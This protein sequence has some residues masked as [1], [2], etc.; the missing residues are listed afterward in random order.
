MDLVSSLVAPAWTS[1]VDRLTYIRRPRRVVDIERRRRLSVV[2][3]NTLLGCEEPAI[4]CWSGMRIGLEYALDGIVSSHCG[5]VDDLLAR[6]V[7]S[8]L[9][10]SQTSVDGRPVSTQRHAT[11]PSRYQVVLLA[12][13]GRAR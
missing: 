13:G 5:L 8:V 3:W 11:R 10:I 4:W 1:K 2:D 6:S 12:S 7:A 9:L